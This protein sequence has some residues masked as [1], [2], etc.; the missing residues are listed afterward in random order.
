MHFTLITVL[1]AVATQSLAAPLPASYEIENL[2][3]RTDS[4]QTW[5]DAI[6]RVAGGAP[7]TVLNVPMQSNMAS[8]VQ[9]AVKLAKG[10]KPPSAPQGRLPSPFV[11]PRLPTSSNF[12]RLQQAL[13]T[14]RKSAFLPPLNKNKGINLQASQK[15]KANTPKAKGSGKGKTSA[16]SSGKG[17]SN[18]KAPGQKKPYV[19]KVT[20]AHKRKTVFRKTKAS[21]KPRKRDLEARDLDIDELN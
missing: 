9:K 8:V 17:R 18:A 10:G 13:N 4:K 2:V 19:R 5:R 14:P 7:D 6:R 20:P 3:A 16:K 21:S 1:A 11:P 15:S 12:A